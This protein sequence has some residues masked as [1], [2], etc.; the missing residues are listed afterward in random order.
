MNCEFIE[1]REK[2]KIKQL[3][4]F[5]VHL[6]KINNNMTHV[7]VN[8]IAFVCFVVIMLDRTS[9]NKYCKLFYLRMLRILLS[10]FERENFLNF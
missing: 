2:K 6:N 4:L 3:S 7:N 8:K 1:K 10:K 5:L 9:S